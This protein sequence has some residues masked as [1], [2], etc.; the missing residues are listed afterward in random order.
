MA[1]QLRPIDD[2]Q[3]QLIK[4]IANKVRQIVAGN[5]AGVQSLTDRLDNTIMPILQNDYQNVAQDDL[6]VITAAVLLGPQMVGDPPL[7]L[8]RE[9][10]DM[11]QRYPQTYYVQIAIKYGV[12]PQQRTWSGKKDWDDVWS[13]AKEELSRLVF[14]AVK[15]A[16]HQL[17]KLL[18]VVGLPA[19]PRYDLE[20]DAE[21]L[22]TR[23]LEPLSSMITD[24]TLTI[25][26]FPERTEMKT[27]NWQSDIPLGARCVLT[28]H[29][30]EGCNIIIRWPDGSETIIPDCAKI[31]IKTAEAFT[32]IRIEPRPKSVIPKIWEWNEAQ[33]KNISNIKVW[34]C[35]CG[36]DSCETKHRLEAWDLDAVPNLHSFIDSAM[37]GPVPMRTGRFAEGMYFALLNE[38]D[39]GLRLRFEEVEFK[40]CRNREEFFEGNR[41]LCGFQFDPRLA[42][43]VTRKL[44]IVVN[45]TAYIPVDRIRCPHRSEHY[46]AITN[47]AAKNTLKAEW[48][49]L[50]NAPSQMS[51]IRKKL[52]W[53]DEKLQELGDAAGINIQELRRK[54][55]ETKKQMRQNLLCPLCGQT[56]VENPGWEPSV[57]FV[58]A[59]WLTYSLDAEGDID[60]GTEGD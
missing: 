55:E 5:Y 36:A 16:Y 24:G 28:V 6:K 42:N 46:E 49:N 20:G 48:D 25:K 44:I 45:P 50:F 27:N 8:L 31:V 4:Q 40:C 9:L 7:L 23:L 51:D 2:G 54:L 14:H 33:I 22:A 30:Q 11:K 59:P 1:G 10:L 47:T 37:C 13:S 15:V 17:R 41:C 38:G 19:R 3:H 26:C 34:E 58:R 35:T 43:K 21:I 32:T 12:I 53:P 18:H 57:V 56:G 60:Y 29:G 52:H 39:Q